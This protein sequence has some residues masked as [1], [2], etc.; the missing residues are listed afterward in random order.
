MWLWWTD[1]CARDVLCDAPPLRSR[2][3]CCCTVIPR[4]P[5][6]SHALWVVH[7]AVVSSRFG[8]VCTSLV[9]R[10]DLVLLMILITG[11]C[12][13]GCFAL[14]LSHDSCLILLSLALVVFLHLALICIYICVLGYMFTL[15]CYF[16]ASWLNSMGIFVL[17]VVFFQLDVVNLS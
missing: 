3:C 9:N 12:L 15:F 17:Y 16:Y 6:L 10:E 4:P 13:W 8:T 11:Y 14:K 5:A 2:F 7:R 1:A